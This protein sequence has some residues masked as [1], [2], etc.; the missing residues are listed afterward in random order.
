MPSK[1]KE[2]NK[3]AL[4]KIEGA[5]SVYE[6]GSLRDE[7]LG[8]LIE[9]DGV[10]LDLSDVNECDVAG[11]QFIL[12]AQRTFDI[13][14]KKLTLCGVSQAVKETAVRTGID[15]KNQVYYEKGV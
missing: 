2:T 7:L 15:S 4:F 3:V 12:S 11:I 9:N 13:A 10:E 6:V 5:L 1:K 8:Y 14:G